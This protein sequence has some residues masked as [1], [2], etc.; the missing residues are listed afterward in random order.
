MRQKRRDVFVTAR[1]LLMSMTFA[2]RA[3]LALDFFRPKKRRDA[4]G[5]F[6][7]DNTITGL[8][9]VRIS[10]AGAGRDVGVDL[11]LVRREIGRIEFG[12]ILDG[13]RRWRDTLAVG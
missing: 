10:D 11:V 12:G 9:E 5:F 4:H 13:T 2:R 7:L 6:R 1:K 8:Q 3:L